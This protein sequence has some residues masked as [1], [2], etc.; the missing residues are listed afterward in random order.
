MRVAERDLEL[1]RGDVEEPVDD[2]GEPVAD[3]VGLLGDLLEAHPVHPVGHEHASP[4]ERGVHARYANERM[5]APEPCQPAVVGGLEF[6]VTLLGHSLGEFGEHVL[7]LQPGHQTAQQRGEHSQVPHVGHHRLGD[8]RVLHLDRDV[9]AVQPRSID[10]PDACCRRGLRLDSLEQVLGWATPL[11]GKHLPHVLPAD[12]R[13]VV[14]QRR[15]PALKVLGLVGIEAGE[16]DGG[17]HLAGLHRRTAHYRELVDQR[18]D[19]RHHAVAPPPLLL[20]FAAASVEPV[21]RPTH[22]P[23]GGH[24]A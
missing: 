11:G 8:P 4:A 21:A 20:G 23:A 5:A 12:R 1:G 18:V 6:V 22:G 19:R 24:P 2:L 16:L 14:A 10:L 3:R 15:E 9:A 13:H 7:H 17:Q